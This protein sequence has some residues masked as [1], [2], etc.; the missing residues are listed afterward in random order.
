MA[1]YGGTIVYGFQVYQSTSTG[2]GIS[3]DNGK[4]WGAWSPSGLTQDYYG[5]NR[6][7][8]LAAARIGIECVHCYHWSSE[9]YNMFKTSDMMHYTYSPYTMILDGVPVVNAWPSGIVA[10]SNG[11]LLGTYGTPIYV[12]RS[13]DAGL[14]WSRIFTSSTEPYGSFGNM[15]EYAPGCVMMLILPS[16]DYV[17]VYRSSD[18]GL[19]WTHA[20]LVGDT[21]S[22]KSYL[23]YLVLLSNG[24]I[25]AGKSLRGESLDGNVNPYNSYLARSVDAGVTWQTLGIADPAYPIIPGGGTWDDTLIELLPGV[26]CIFRQY[27]GSVLC[28]VSFN[29]GDTWE[30][31]GPVFSGDTSMTMQYLRRGRYNEWFAKTVSTLLYPGYTSHLL[32]RLQYLVSL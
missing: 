6:L 26:L 1:F 2:F 29:S 31:R 13:V 23:K 27:T 16:A 19:T 30:P 7:A 3:L 12:V 20:T 24:I 22:L 10:L 28:Y 17:Q 8:A 11:V 32:Y 18:F 9:T 15:V 5:Y 21:P 14:T 25:L 4:T